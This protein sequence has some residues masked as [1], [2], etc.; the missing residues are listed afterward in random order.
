MDLCGQ[1]AAFSH[2]P[3]DFLSTTS[4]VALTCMNTG[5]DLCIQMSGNRAEFMNMD[6]DVTPFGEGAGYTGQLEISFLS[7]NTPTGG[8]HTLPVPHTCGDS[9]ILELFRC[10][11]LHC[12]SSNQKS[13]NKMRLALLGTKCMTK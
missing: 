12:N 11:F 4:T 13:V 6:E 9:S 10:V 8:A 1:G 5:K 3:V 2:D 7:E